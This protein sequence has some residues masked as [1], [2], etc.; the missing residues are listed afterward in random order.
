MLEENRNIRRNLR[1]ADY[2]SGVDALNA[3]NQEDGGGSDVQFASFKAG[4]TYKVKVLGASDLISFFSYGIYKQLN[5]FVAKNPSKKSKNGYPVEHLTPFDLAWKF[6]KDKSKDFSDKHGQ[7]AAKYRCKQRFA[8]GFFDLESGEPIIIDVSKPQGQA[9]Y[10]TIKKYESKLGK[11]A[12]ELSKQGSGT[13]TTVSLTPIIDMEEDLT[14]KERDNF[15]KAPAE[16]NM[17]LFDGLLYE[18]DDEEM[19]QN[20]VKVGFDVSLIGLAASKQ[21]GDEDVE[22]LG[23]IDEETL[24][25]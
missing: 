3:L 15:A 10:G 20:L 12:F 4:T 25:F 18:A 5:S 2:M 23:D 14:D 11:L 1:M 17:S 6:H 24:P 9:I 7:E 21:G 22:P 19:I 8:M 16:F 13:N